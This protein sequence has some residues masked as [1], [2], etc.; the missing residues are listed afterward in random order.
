MNRRQANAYLCI[1][2]ET[3]AQAPRGKDVGGLGPNGAQICQTCQIEPSL[4]LQYSVIWR[5]S[6]E[7]RRR[8]RNFERTN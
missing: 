2:L 8:I 6:V 7:H 5:M 3:L 4:T 1:I